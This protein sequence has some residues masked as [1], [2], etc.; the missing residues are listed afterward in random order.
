MLELQDIGSRQPSMESLTGAGPDGSHLHPGH[1]YAA[2][3]RSPS[4]RFVFFFYNPRNDSVSFQSNVFSMFKTDDAVHRWYERLVQ[5]DEIIC[6]L[7]MISVF[8][9]PYRM[10]LKLWK[11]TVLAIEA[12]DRMT[13]IHA[14]C[15]PFISMRTDLFRVFSLSN[16]IVSNTYE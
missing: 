2:N 14:V 1:Q 8:R 15:S 16:W 7:S 12:I 6:I 5:E 13:D 4:L 11:K 3:R 10:W 9:I